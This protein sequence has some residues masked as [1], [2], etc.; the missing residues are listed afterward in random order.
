MQKSVKLFTGLARVMIVID[1]DD[2]M[3]ERQNVC[4]IDVINLW[5]DMVTL[6]CA[7]VDVK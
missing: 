7:H 3:A 2:L 6:M 4:H 5:S 1:E